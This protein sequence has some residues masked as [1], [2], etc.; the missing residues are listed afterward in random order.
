[1]HRFISRLFSS[2][3]LAIVALPAAATPTN[4]PDGPPG[5]AG[6]LAGIPTTAVEQPRGGDA[7]SGQVAMPVPVPVALPLKKTEVRLSMSGGLIEGEV[8][9]TFTNNTNTALEA[10]YA[11]PLPSDATVTGMELQIGERVIRSVVK[12]REEARQKYE[13]A[14]ESGR[15]AALLDEERPNIFT[16]SVANFNPGETVRIRFTYLQ[17]AEY[18]RGEYGLTFPMV[19]GPR[20]IP[21]RIPVPDADR[22]TPPILHPSIDSGH[23]LTLTA[24]IT[25]L[26]VKAITSS[27]HAIVSTP[28][29]PGGAT[30]DVTL[31]E[32]EALPNSEFHLDIALDGGAEPEVSVVTTQA[33]ESKFALV[34]L[35]PPLGV[36]EEQRPPRVPRDILFLIDTSG[37]MNGESI[38]QAQAGLLKCVDMLQPEDAFTIVR[39]ASEYSA[40]APALRRATPETM[41]AARSYV[42]SLRADGG[43]EMQPALDYTLSI[44]S[45]RENVLRLVV[46]LTDG[47]VG[48][49]DSLMRLLHARLGSA[50]VFTFG[51]GSA[52]NEYLMRRLAEIGRGQSRFIRSHE[53]IGAVMSDF[54]R[55]LDQPALT[56][57]KLEWQDREGK[58]VPDLIAYPQLCPDVFVDRPVQVVAKLPAKFDGTLVVK[59]NV[60]GGSS[61]FKF[62][63]GAAAQA[64]HAGISTLFGRAVVNDLMYRRLRTN[65]AGELKNL[66]DE[67]VKTAL[68]YQLVTEFTSRVAVEEQITRAPDGRLARAAVPTMLPRGWNPAGFFRTATNDPLQLT[69]GMI[70]WVA[71]IM[72]FI[73]ETQQRPKR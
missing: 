47:D 17:A 52:P 33:H 12:E 9:Q 61:A 46:F 59:G 4:P 23:R 54:F 70:A 60:S 73:G 30:Y 22:V 24:T 68:E 37:S 7:G 35:F 13:A 45:E 10:I 18:E 5:I 25:G 41:E 20:Y 50:R 71:G 49:E 1:M 72:L 42:R 40:F 55:T 67:V 28:R 31:R 29:D 56:N 15:K 19:V 27:T 34:T 58:A 51:I 32:G 2:L 62:P 8:V 64:Q 53:D 3:L 69:L 43:T 65:D 11:F 39:F 38:G 44:P 57:V 48:N 26:P 21:F 6:I 16:T 63:L 66:R 14:R 36:P